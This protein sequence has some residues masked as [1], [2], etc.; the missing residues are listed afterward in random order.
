[1]AS[2]MKYERKNHAAAEQ[3]ELELEWMKTVALRSILTRAL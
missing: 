3:A 1:M 2:Q